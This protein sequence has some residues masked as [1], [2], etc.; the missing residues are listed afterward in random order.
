M[1]TMFGILSSFHWMFQYSKLVTLGLNSL[2]TLAWFHTGPVDLWTQMPATTYHI[3][4]DRP[5]P[6]MPKLNETLNENHGKNHGIS[7]ESPGI[8]APLSARAQVF[9][10]W[11]WLA[12]GEVPETR[13]QRWQRWMGYRWLQMATV[14]VLK[15]WLWFLCGFQ[16]SFSRCVADLQWSARP[17]GGL[18]FEGAGATSSA[19]LLSWPGGNQKVLTPGDRKPHW[20]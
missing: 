6:K 5:H 17:R 14:D 13:W 10:S 18:C 20:P 12:N 11:S 1:S 9:E 8:M 4:V 7:A 16:R 19:R 2:H 3:E 15:I